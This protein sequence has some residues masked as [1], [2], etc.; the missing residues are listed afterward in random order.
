V[1]AVAL[2]ALYPAVAQAEAAA[3]WALNAT[4][5]ESCSCPM[6]CTCYFS[7]HPAAAAG[8]G[9]GHGDGHGGEEHY[10]RFNMAY[11]VNSGHHGDVD[12]AG[13]KF[14]IAGD[15]GD[16]FGDGE[17]D[18]AILTFDPA[19]TPEQRAGIAAA[20][21]H[22]FPVEWKSFGMG[23]DAPIHWEASD[24]RAVAKLDDGK[25]GEIVLTN[26]VNSNQDAPVVIDNLK[27]WGAP[28]NEGFVLMPNEIN[29]WRLGDKAFETRGT[30]GFMIT[31]DMNSGD[32]AP[33]AAGR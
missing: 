14:W 7:D 2:L 22:V 23:E 3:D 20:L 15:L 25:A 16:N 17:T 27:Y 31:I 12:L 19:V 1:G 24:A 21:P 18:W 26:A 9:D 5:I 13:A 10:C 4:A 11:K 8:H 6:F 29:A 30:N 28:R 33:A 32:V